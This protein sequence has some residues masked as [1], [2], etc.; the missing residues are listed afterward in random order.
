MQDDIASAL[1]Q[2]VK[3]EVIEHYLYERRLME[4]QM[5]YV[6]ELAHHAAQLQE[7]LYK[8]FARMYDLLYE[9]KF[10][11]EFLRLLNVKGA[12]FTDSFAK[13][14]EYQNGVRF[15]KV[16]GFSDRGRFKKLLLESYRRLH[17]WN[18]QYKE[19]YEDLAQECKAVRDNLKKFEEDHDLL[20]ILNFLR[21]MDVEGIKRKHFLGENFTPEEIGSI[22]SSLRFKPVRVEQFKLIAPPGLPSLDA[23]RR[24]L[25]DL[26]DSVY[27][28]C[29]DRLKE[30]I[31]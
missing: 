9:T 28:R 11:N 31:K 22:E 16:R 29:C 23:I 6:K 26:A 12:P 1:T 20:T 27:D 17:G 15:I 2:E 4:G 30:L 18:D 24:Q 7:K 10:V 14:P 5:D 8:R 21:D 3:E 19:A 13:A 25:S